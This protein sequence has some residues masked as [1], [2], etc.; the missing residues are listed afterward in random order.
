MDT[1]NI[2]ITVVSV[3]FVLIV[4][5]VVLILIY[6][7]KEDKKST[8]LTKW[9]AVGGYDVQI[10][11]SQNGINWSEVNKRLFNVKINN[12][13]TGFANKVA[14]GLTTGS[15]PIWI[16]VGRS[17]EGKQIYYSSDGESWNSTT[18]SC[19]GPAD[20]EADGNGIAYGLSSN[21]TTG[22]WVAAGKIE[23]N[24]T[25]YHRNLLYSLDGKEWNTSTGISFD[26]DGNHV[27]YGLSSNNTTGIWTA[28][29]THTDKQKNILYSLDG[30]EWLA[31]TGSSFSNTGNGIAYGLSS[32][33]TTGIW[34]ASGQDLT[35]DGKASTG[36]NLLFS[37]DGQ[38]WQECTGVSFKTTSNRSPSVIAF[39]SNAAYGLSSD[40]ETGIWVATGM[41]N[42]FSLLYSLN[43]QEWFRT[44]GASFGSG[45]YASDVAYGL[46]DDNKTGIWVA[47]GT[48]GNQILYSYDGI[49]WKLS[50][51]DIKFN[52]I[53]IGNGGGVASD[54]TNVAFKNTGV[55]AYLPAIPDVFPNYR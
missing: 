33:N 28:I 22:I 21:N 24:I 15:E 8:F 49:E 2:I 17:S 43:G 41:D 34:V 42:E 44:T 51:D 7:K 48:G 30:K 4:I 18:G 6:T 39:A 12:L 45:Q 27:A 26:V 29:G 14:H 25:D 50:Q 10:Y 13:N 23:N 53:G 55:S 9:L 5:A 35:G 40:K 47:T 31:S 3:I 20:R 32:N 16:M 19:F 1:K 36:K 46:T 38:D 11:R 37:L 52:P 54:L